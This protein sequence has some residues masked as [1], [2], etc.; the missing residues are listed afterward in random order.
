MAAGDRRADVGGPLPPPSE[1][2]GSL[3]VPSGPANTTR[4]GS[5]APATRRPPPPAPRPAVPSPPSRAVTAEAGAGNPAST[6]PEVLRLDSRGRCRGRSASFRRPPASCE[7]SV[8]ARLDADPI[9][10][11]R[12][13]V[14]LVL[15][16]R[17]RRLRA[18][19]LLV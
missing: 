11:A 16:H 10:V 4:R 9:R 14:P 7:S 13:L 2:R 17:H 18:A 19:T 8:R 1:A 12:L 3:V 15:D 6:G 5:S